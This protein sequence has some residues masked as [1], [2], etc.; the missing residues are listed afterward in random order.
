MLT[1]DDEDHT[2]TF[3]VFRVLLSFFFAMIFFLFFLG[4]NKRGGRL[5]LHERKKK[6]RRK[7]V[8][9]TTRNNNKKTSNLSNQIKIRY[10]SLLPTPPM[11]KY[12]AFGSDVPLAEPSWC[13][14]FSSFTTSSS[15]S[16]FFFLLVS[17][18]R[19]NFRFDDVASRS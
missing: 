15:S 16:L 11:V 13:A 10:M 9:I 2:L 3:Y 8:I 5:F 1:V 19:Y 18:C 4:S 14:L 7:V 12:D 6:K 17:N